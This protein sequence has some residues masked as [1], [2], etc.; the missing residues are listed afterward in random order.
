[1]AKVYLGLGSNL[2][3]K[4]A[5]LR[6]AIQLIGKRVGTVASVSAFY[7]TEPWGFRSENTFLNAAVEVNTPLSPHQLLE[8]TQAIEIALGRKAK[9]QNHTY[10]DRLVDIDILLYD[11]LILNDDD[12]VI[13]H[14]LM[15]KR[16]FVME[17][18]AEIAAEV[19]VAGT[20]RMVGEIYYF[21]DK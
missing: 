15:T 19:M 9:S 2:G 20:G 8:G 11:D 16:R 10:T 17:P 7:V 18:L 3:D 6:Q 14:P 21:L 12:L 1:M 13:P 4:E 5:H